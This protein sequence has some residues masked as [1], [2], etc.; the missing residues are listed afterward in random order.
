[1]GL[2]QALG[3]NLNTA[4]ESF[5]VAWSLPPKRT[6]DLWIDIIHKSPMLDPVSMIAADV[7]GTNFKIFDKA[8][9]RKDPA[10]AEPYG[11]HPIFDLLDNPMPDHPE[12]DYYQLMYLTVVYHEIVGDTFW[13]IDRDTR[14]RPVGIYLV[15]PNWMLLTPTANIPFFRI[16]PMG[17]TSHRYF[18]ADPADVVWF[19]APDAVNPYGRGRAR[20]E[21]IG[22]EI[23]THE[24]SSKYAKNF[25]Y[26]DATP[27][28]ILE[29]PG[30][31]KADADSFKESWMQKIGG[32]LNA[33]K[34]S[35]I[36]QKDFKVHQLATNP[37]EM[38]FVE[39]RKYLIQMA[40]EHFCVPP[41][42]RGNLQ[43]SNRATIDSAFYLWT[44]NVVTRRLKVI[45]AV[46]NKQFIPM[47]DTK[48]KWVFDEIVPED[49]EFRLKVL[50]AGITA[51]TV[52]R[53]E[54][55]KGMKLPLDTARGDVYLTSFNITETPANKKAPTVAPEPTPPED[56]KPLPEPVKQLSL[57]LCL[58]ELEEKTS[59]FKY[60]P[61][62]PRGEDGKWGDGGA[63]SSGHEP[64][65]D[66]S[67]KASAEYYISETG[68][69]LNEA[70]RMDYGMND[71]Q[72]QHADKLDELISNS[73]VYDGTLYRGADNGFT[74]MI[75][76][77]VGLDL[78]ADDG[79]YTELFSGFSLEDKGYVSTS[80]SESFA[81]EFSREN[82]G[83]GT[84][85]KLR[86]ES[87]SLDMV[88]A[89]GKDLV[90][91]KER[92][93][94]RDSSIKVTSAKLETDKYGNSMLVIEGVI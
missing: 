57:D 48:T 40:N 28:I 55:R 41:E 73:D 70:L 32:Y 37:K 51:G 46:I 30:I 74:E 76:D 45:Q 38:D 17:N 5:K 91:E 86:S 24:F 49:E 3:A 6:T 27:P 68:I 56:K 67:A 90:Q 69:E 44:K 21:A 61:D 75:A 20:A 2:F 79:D 80:E 87:R 71:E 19:K 53:N 7:A 89:A 78:K 84:L 35:V 13:L 4:R 93:F 85:L 1:M 66:D 83:V 65:Y 23:E 88:R 47:F 14:G 58:K 92:L 59:F 77:S 15:P 81:K 42:M 64:S 33:R 34:P 22:D 60:S 63:G 36:G 62:Q 12:I 82:G 50:S 25:Y 9:H 29:M 43:N 94:S 16:Q 52:T 72:Q 10:N 31:S 11:D 18:N 26:N 8:Q 39:S 54:W